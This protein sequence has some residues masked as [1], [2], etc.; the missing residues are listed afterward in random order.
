MCPAGSDWSI[1]VKFPERSVS[2]T[3][4]ATV[5]AIE[6][7]H[8]YAERID[9]GVLVSPMVEVSVSDIKNWSKSYSIR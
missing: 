6:A 9:S 7:A 2:G 8:F 4:I 3:V 1:R 5:R